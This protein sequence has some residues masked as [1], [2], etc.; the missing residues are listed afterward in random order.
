MSLIS[1]IMPAYNAEL[2]IKQACYSV[3]E[4][5]YTNWELIVVDDGS[6]DRTYELLKEIADQ[7]PAVRVIHTENGG[8]SK[9]RNI[10]LDHA[11]GD[12]ILLLD[13]D[14]M[15]VSNAL[16]L[17][18]NAIE[19]Y[20][21]DMAIGW[22]TDMSI[23]GQIQGCPYHRE[24]RLLTGE[25]SLQCSLRDQPF[26]YAAWGKLYRKSLIDNIRF[27]EGKRIHEDTFFVF[28]CCLKQPKIILLED[29][30]VQYR[31]TPNSAS[32][33]VFSDKFFDILFF[34]E[35][36][37]EAIDQLYPQHSDL[38]DNMFIKA[39]MAML[40]NL[41]RTQ[42]KRYKKAEKQCIKEI[43]KRKDKFIVALEAD[44]RFFKIITHHMYGIY[45][46]LLHIL[47]KV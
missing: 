33:S 38:A 39:N 30:V 47:K 29:I 18:Y 22:K 3:I 35:K 15:L 14:D 7:H 8:V 26:L 41:C 16:E 45:K 4:Q 32:R 40:R 2:W 5:T 37:K 11:K 21:A 43:I 31:S 44:R 19:T 1:I 9:A 25:E 10:G 20:R 23:D 27:T 36:K 17:L 28:Q 12:Y 13:A 34:A 46:I 6:C 24:K 42:D